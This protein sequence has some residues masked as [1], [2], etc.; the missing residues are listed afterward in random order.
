MLFDVFSLDVHKVEEVGCD[1]VLEHSVEEFASY[2][3]RLRV[4]RKCTCVNTRQLRSIL[5]C[6]NLITCSIHR[7]YA[8]CAHKGA[9]HVAAV[10]RRQP[11]QVASSL[12]GGGWSCM[13]L[14]RSTADGDEGEAIPL[15][16]GSGLFKPIVVS[17]PGY[18][19][20]EVHIRRALLCS[21]SA[22]QCCSCRHVSVH[23]T[24]H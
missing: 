13:H 5:W 12:H 22:D 9:S 17:V 1:G 10:Q 11:V 23:T 2:G 15:H 24:R 8:V 19:C 6:S 16:P 21:L 7:V 20:G 18:T 3:S 14:A 4:K